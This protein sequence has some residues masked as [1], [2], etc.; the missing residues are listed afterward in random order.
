MENDAILR[1]VGVGVTGD[2]GVEGGLGGGGRLG[3]WGRR[4]DTP[5]CKHTFQ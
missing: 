4:E 1:R 2:C 5:A 3:G